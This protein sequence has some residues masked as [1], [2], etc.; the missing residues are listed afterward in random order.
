M[1]NDIIVNTTLIGL[2]LDKFNNIEDTF[3]SIN[4]L[5][6]MSGSN[7]K[8]NE[9]FDNHPSFPYITNLKSNLIE[10]YYRV[11]QL[12]KRIFERYGRCGFVKSTRG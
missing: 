11:C 8:P 5:A 3:S 1:K 6:D 4:A 12:A 9:L 7:L 2:K 10:E